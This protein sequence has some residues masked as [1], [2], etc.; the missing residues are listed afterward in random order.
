MEL[1]LHL[2]WTQLLE[3]IQCFSCIYFCGF[4][5]VSTI[6]R[7]K[8]TSLCFFRCS[9]QRLGTSLISSSLPTCGYSCLWTSHLSFWHHMLLSYCLA[10]GYWVCL[11]VVLYSLPLFCIMLMKRMLQLFFLIWHRDLTHILL[12]LLNLGF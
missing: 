4:H 2:S 5:S 10:L 7:M 11:D 8:L 1:V 3:L 9:V 6:Y 12:W